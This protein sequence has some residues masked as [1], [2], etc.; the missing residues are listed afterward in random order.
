[1]SSKTT[2]Y[3]LHKIDLADSPPDITVLNQNFDIIDEQLKK[4]YSS[5]NKPTASDVGLGNVNNTSDANKPVSTAQATAIADAKKAGTDAQTNLET[6]IADTNNP[7]SVTKSQVG[8]G[9]VPNVATNNQT[10]TYTAAST[11]AALVSGEK[12]SVAFGKIA[13]AVSD[14]I[15]HL[16]NKSNPHGVTADQAD[17]LPCSG[18]TMRSA[19]TFEKSGV[20][21]GFGR[22]IKNHSSDADYGMYISDIDVDGDTAKFILS[23]KNDKMHYGNTAGE[24]KEIFHEGNTDV[25]NDATK[26]YVKTYYHLSQL[27]LTA[28]SET[29]VD[30]INAMPDNSI[31]EFQIGSSNNLE[32]YPNSY[33]GTLVVHRST[34]M[35]NDITFTRAQG[36]AKWYGTVYDGA[37]SGWNRYFTDTYPPTAVQVGALP[38]TGGVTTGVISTNMASYPASRYLATSSNVYGEVLVGNHNLQITIRNVNGDE[39]NQRTIFLADS[40]NAS[41]IIKALRLRVKASNVESWYSLFGN[42]NKTKGSYTGNSSST[43][44]KIDTKSYGAALVIWSE[45]SSGIVTPSGAIFFTGSTY[46][47]FSSND[48]SYSNGSIGEGI[49]EMTSTNEHFNS[50]SYTYYYQA[51]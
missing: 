3:N 49:L 41:D 24:T 39:S 46:K 50:S 35:R 14:L 1:M 33:Y 32:Q 17:A 51:L 30:I 42:H 45:Y 40:T 5:D 37:F 4:S 16:A 38:N 23:A 20:N 28:G 36:N 11:L 12:L 21:N 27:G 6:H 8:L 18:G 7:H 34:N 15:S 44:R 25:L 43:Q 48:I 29:L 2:N 26:Q 47:S 9:N 19:I 13:K 22:I 31:A 10:P